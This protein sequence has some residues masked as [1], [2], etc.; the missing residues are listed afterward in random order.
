MNRK[1]TLILCFAMS[2]LLV[3][4]SG[5]TAQFTAPDEPVAPLGTAFTYQ[6]QLTEDGGPA[7]GAYDFRF[8]LYNAETGG[9]QVGSTLNVPDLAVNRGL[10]TATLDFGLGAFDGQARWLEVAVRRGASSGVFTVLSP[11]QALTATPYAVF[12]KSAPWSGLSGVPAGFA[13]NVDND[14][15]YTA[16]DGLA[17]TSNQFSVNFAE[18]GS[19]PSAA[20]SDHNHLG[21]TWT[22]DGNPLVITGIFTDTAPLSG[23][24]ASGYGFWGTYGN[25]LG[26]PGW[27]YSGLIG[28]SD[29]GNGIIGVTARD[30]GVGVIG[31]S[32][33][34]G[35]GIY[36]VTYGGGY[37]AGFS[38]NVNV[39][40][41]LFVSG[42]KPFRIDYP[43]D[44]ANK[45]LIHYSVESPQVQNQYNGTVTLDANGEAVVQLPDYFLTINT[46]PYSYQ[47][48]AIGSPGPNLY[49]AQEVADN[50]FKIAGGT[51]GMKV[52]WLLYAMRN[53]P[54]LRDNPHTDVVDKPEAE[55]GTYIYP[56]GYGV[57][58]SLQLG[59]QTGFSAPQ[60][61]PQEP[62]AELTNPSDNSTGAQNSTF[63]P[64]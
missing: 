38:G 15:T 61:Q 49:I 60:P 7:D 22:G 20:R 31:Q 36:G 40:G 12:S 51:P 62:G 32:N 19:S 26:I 41:D 11:R 18:D 47:L 52:S 5:A 56:Q 43:A 10:F 4:A 57:D 48:T 28:D 46:G 35:W 14:T 17:L 13:D 37:S 44:P 25:R 21:E 27:W 50:Q 23:Y 42:A 9:S 58:A 53:D 29:I 1:F 30:T 8:I 55:R 24:N 3:G 64:N 63:P 2:A 33:N 6:G 59:P 54:Y 39:Y 45:Y 16:G 34:Y